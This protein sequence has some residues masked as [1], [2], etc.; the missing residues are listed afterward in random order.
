[1]NKLSNGLRIGLAYIN[2]HINGFQP[3]NRFPP[4]VLSMI[5]LELKVHYT[6]CDKPSECVQHYECLR[7][8][9]VCRYWRTVALGCSELWT[10][11]YLS[12][13][14]IDIAKLFCERSAQRLLSLVV[15]RLDKS[16]SSI[17]MWDVIKASSERIK[18]LAV[19]YSHISKWPGV[20]EFPAMTTF[21]DHD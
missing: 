9:S 15:C 3:I 7:I 6:Y 14:T 10:C 19:T 1:M 17:R 8:F 16:E 12:P 5:F 18:K 13:N 20:M 21:I 2:E 11:V 4:E